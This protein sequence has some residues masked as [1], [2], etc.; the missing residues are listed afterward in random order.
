MAWKDRSLSDYFVKLFSSFPGC[1]E[2]LTEVRG[3]FHSPNYPGKYPDGQ[4]CSWG[5]MV[6]VTPHIH[7]TFTNF[8]LH[9]ENN[10]DALYVY[11]G[12]NATG[13]VLGVFYGSNPPPEGGIYSMTNQMFIIFKSDNQ[14][15]SYTG[16]NAS[17]YGLNKSG[18]CS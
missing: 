16:F 9:H 17:C 2:T 13:E 6:N 14:T 7:L 18:K 8:S 3:T 12:E 11:D 1:N 15:G 10:T 4:Y 5:I